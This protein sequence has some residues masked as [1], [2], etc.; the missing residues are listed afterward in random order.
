[1]ALAGLWR[2]QLAAT[3]STSRFISSAT[4]SVMT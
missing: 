3:R 2:T 4:V 1:M